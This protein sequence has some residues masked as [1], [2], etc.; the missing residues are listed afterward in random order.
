ME[1]GS[2]FLHS[3]LKTET[4]FE[5]SNSSSSFDS[6]SYINETKSDNSSFSST[7]K[8]ENLDPESSSENLLELETSNVIAF[9]LLESYF[10][11]DSETSSEI[12]SF[13]RETPSFGKE[14]SLIEKEVTSFEKELQTLSS[15]HSKVLV[16]PSP[17]PK[18]RNSL[19]KS[20]DY[21][22]DSSDD[23]SSNLWNLHPKR[24][25]SNLAIFTSILITS[26]STSNEKS[27]TSFRHKRRPCRDPK[28]K[29]ISPPLKKSSFYLINHSPSS[30]TSSS[31]VPWFS[32]SIQFH[33]EP[34]K[35]PASTT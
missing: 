32:S 2:S 7:E 19:V 4:S 9:S 5:T 23:S 25:K 33:P 6:S 11:F 20:S 34:S 12:S 27:E 14:R 30:N 26:K 1:K 31:L 35:F 21:S 24:N 8:I 13:K 18:K 22:L 15:L 17:H 16:T 28:L 29:R 10:S 3:S